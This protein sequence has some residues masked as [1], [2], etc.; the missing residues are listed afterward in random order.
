MMNMG[1]I[2]DSSVFSP[3]DW[4]KVRRQTDSAI[5]RWIDDQMK[6]VKA[7]IV[8]VG[9]STAESRWVRHEIRKAW[10]EY[11]PL[12]GVRIHKLMDMNGHTSLAGSNPFSRVGLQN[13]QKVS[14]YVPLI[15][16]RGNS[17]REVYAD[18]ANNLEKWVDDY[19]Y[20]RG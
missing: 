8:L 2:S 14:D 1:A 19:A 4:E 18:I 10:D 7:V 5:E 3:Q 6:Y 16:P 9:S 20:R 15:E 17:S 12:L 13:G 11:Y